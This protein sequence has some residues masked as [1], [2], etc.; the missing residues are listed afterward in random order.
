MSKMM[1]ISD[2]TADRLDNLSNNMKTSKQK[3]IDL[4]VKKFAR[5]KF[6]EEAAEDYA[7]LKNDKEAWSEIQK[8]RS[9]WDSTLL[10]ELGDE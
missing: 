10:D 3:I 9:L 8:E 7:A 6:L 2:V 4:A 5:E 1:R